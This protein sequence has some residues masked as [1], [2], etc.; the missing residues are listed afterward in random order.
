MS[1]L[2]RNEVV[3]PEKRNAVIG[4]LRIEI[5]KV[6]D[7]VRN[8]RYTDTILQAMQRNADTLQSYLDKFI[9]KK[10]VIT[11]TE[12]NTVLDTMNSLKKQ[13]MGMEV[14]LDRKRALLIAAIFIIGT[15]AGILL[16]KKY[17]K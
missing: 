13:R 3:L 14:S 5:N 12:T 10:G 6:A 17:A 9:N 11:P 4:E 15:T 1:L 8:K 16:Y 2:E 7:D